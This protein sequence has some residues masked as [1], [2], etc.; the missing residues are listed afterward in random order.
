MGKENNYSFIVATVL[1]S[2]F[3]SIINPKVFIPIIAILFTLD[4]LVSTNRGGRITKSIQSAVKKITLEGTSFFVTVISF[5]ISAISNPIVFILSMLML[6]FVEEFFKVQFLPSGNEGVGMINSMTSTGYCIWAFLSVAIYSLLTFGVY[7]KLKVRL[8][9]EMTLRDFMQIYLYSQ[10]L[11]APFLLL[12]VAVLN[13][14]GI[15]LFVAFGGFLVLLPVMFIVNM[16]INQR[17]DSALKKK[18]PDAFS[19][20]I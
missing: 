19:Q 15:L 10:I 20:K 6:G 14:L 9:N 18:Y 12:E 2:A 7:I 17:F 11:W 13:N 1:I 4:L 8:I 5:L 3:L 16:K